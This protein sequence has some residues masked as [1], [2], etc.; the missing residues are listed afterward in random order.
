MLIQDV[1]IS[2][3]APSIGYPLVL[4]VGQED[5]QSFSPLFTKETGRSCKTV[6]RL[7]T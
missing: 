3:R 7:F 1:S 6:N 4:L 2:L 5:G